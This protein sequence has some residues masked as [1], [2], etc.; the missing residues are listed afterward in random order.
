MALGGFGLY[1]V[2]TAL[3]A[4]R[5]EFGPYLSPFFSPRLG[6]MGS[7]SPALWILPIPLLFRTSCYHYR[8]AYHRSFFG[9]PLACGRPEGRRRSYRGETRLP[10]SLN[11]LHRLALYLSLI[12]LAFL[13]VDALESFS[14]GG[15]ARVGL[16]SLLMLLNVILLSGYTLGCHSLRHL[17]GGGLDCYSRARCGTARRGAWRGVTALTARHGVWAWSSLAGV[18]AVDV[19]IRALQHGLVDA[20]IGG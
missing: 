7:V 4:G 6:G 11:N 13:W 1:G 8:K 19:Y 17:A 3:V 5:S 9:H 14:S 15:R 12:V 20:H 2:W 16:G 18:V 10:L